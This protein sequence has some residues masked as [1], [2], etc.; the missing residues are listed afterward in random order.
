[1]QASDPPPPHPSSDETPTGPEPEAAG[2]SELR[3]APERIG[4]VPPH[5]AANIP[6]LASLSQR[7]LGAALDAF[8]LAIPALLLELRHRPA[9]IGTVPPSL[10]LGILAGLSILG[11]INLHLL[12]DRGQTIGKLAVQSRIVLL[13]GSP[14]GFGRI[15][16][17]R[18][19]LNGLLGA[20]LPVY[21]FL[22]PLLI[23]RSDRRCVHDFLAGTIVV[24]A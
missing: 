9:E 21:L 19:L 4:A 3:E 12:L 17:R 7:F 6:P 8:L 16:W 1:M 11:A 5:E 15:L 20:G 10:M 18:S 2:G 24:Q 22:D 13:D 14:A 23:F